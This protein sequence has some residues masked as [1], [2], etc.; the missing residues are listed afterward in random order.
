[1]AYPSF[2]LEALA[3]RSANYYE[4]LV[5]AEGLPYFNVFWTEP[6]EAAH[7]WPDFGDVMSR[8]LQGAIML[9]RMT[10]VETVSE[11]AWLGKTLSLI[12]PSDG[13]LHRPETSF[14]KPV[15]DFGDAALTL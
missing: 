7:D 12:D 11:K 13:L 14:S 3:A 4:R 5:D 9:R 10:G 6:A 2:S 1:M 8:Q 15:A